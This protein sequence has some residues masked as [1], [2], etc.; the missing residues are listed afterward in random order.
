MAPSKSAAHRSNLNNSLGRQMDKAQHLA[1]F[2]IDNHNLKKAYADA[3]VI[4]ET[5]EDD[6]DVDPDENTSKD[7]QTL[8][9]IK[10]VSTDQTVGKYEQVQVD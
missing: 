2:G 10:E 8:N 5:Q 9:D 6:S 7:N 4:I 3:S 1:R